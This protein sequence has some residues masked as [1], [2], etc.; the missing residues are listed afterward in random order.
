MF[1]V[2]RIVPSY[3][4]RDAINGWSAHAIGVYSSSDDALDVACELGE[5]A[6]PT[7]FVVVP[8]GASPFDQKAQVHRPYAPDADADIPF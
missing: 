6:E 2:Y 8:L 7:Y 4:D 5:D 1:Q 3:C